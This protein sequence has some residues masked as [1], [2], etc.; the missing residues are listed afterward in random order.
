MEFHGCKVDESV[1]YHDNMS[2]ILLEKNRRGSGGKHTRHISI[3]YFFVTDRVNSKEVK[4][5]YCPTKEMI[6]DSFTKPLQGVKFCKFRDL[7]FNV[8]V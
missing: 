3:R 6:S 4:V 5:E 1:V 2:S 7:V 8:Q